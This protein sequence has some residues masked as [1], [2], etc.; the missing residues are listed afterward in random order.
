MAMNDMYAA[1]EPARAEI[2]M[3]DGPTVIEF[4][5]SWCGYCKAAQPLLASAFAGHPRV[6]HIKIEDGSGRPLGRSFKVK[7]WPT[8]VFLSHGREIARLVRPGDASAIRQG[9][10]QI[11]V[12]D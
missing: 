5:T 6:R 12:P 1:I 10:A 4:G 7:L 8:L 2:D 11:D 3:L 9:L